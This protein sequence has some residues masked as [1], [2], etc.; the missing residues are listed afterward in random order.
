MKECS[1]PEIVKRAVAAD[2]RQRGL[3]Y[4]D[5]A[6]LTTYKAPTIAN[7]MSNKKVY[8]THKQAER[9]KQFG[10]SE[11]YLTMGIGTLRPEDNVA[12]AIDG[13]NAFLPDSSKLMLLMEFVRNIGDILDDPLIKA[14]YFKFYKAV[15]TTD[16]H[17]CAQALA[18]IQTLIAMEMFKRGVAYDESGM[19]VPNPPQG[20]RTK[21]ESSDQNESLR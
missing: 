1:S 8:F 9:L 19:L 4:G 13:G 21:H 7:V 10:Y 6:R 3:T 11:E 20:V 15:T 12:S 14:V 17:E 18:A 16:Q 2:W 5:V